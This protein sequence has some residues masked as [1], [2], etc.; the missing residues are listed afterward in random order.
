MRGKETDVEMALLRT[1]YMPHQNNNNNNKDNNKDKDDEDKYAFNSY[2]RML[3]VE[4]NCIAS[5]FAQL[6]TKVGELHRYICAKVPGCECVIP[7]ENTSA[8]KV[9]ESLALAMRKSKS[10]EKYGEKSV[11]LMVV[12]EDDVFYADQ[13]LLEA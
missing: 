8:M 6:S 9:V 2:G 1:D 11:L 3:Q 5:A 7:A 12:L 4:V 10:W 13:R